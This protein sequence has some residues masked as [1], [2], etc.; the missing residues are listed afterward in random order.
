LSSIVGGFIIV[1]GFING[2][3]DGFIDLDKDAS[4]AA[5]LVDST[6]YRMYRFD[7][8]VFSTFF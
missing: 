3:I 8:R 1:D 4:F 5:F 6:F 7:L 2:F